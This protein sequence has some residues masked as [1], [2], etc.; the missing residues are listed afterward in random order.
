[1]AEQGDDSQDC[2][3]TDPCGTLRGAISRARG[4]VVILVH[5]GL[6]TG[7][8]QSIPL[9]TQTNIS[10]QCVPTGQND[11]CIFD[12]KGKSRFLTRNASSEDN[13]FIEL[14]GLV[15]KNGFVS[16]GNGGLIMTRNVRCLN[17]ENC[18]FISDAHTLQCDVGKALAVYNT[19]VNLKNTVFDFVSDTD[20]SIVYVEGLYPEN[21]PNIA[22]TIYNVTFLEK[23]SEVK[24]SMVCYTS[25]VSRKSC[26]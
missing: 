1:M 9:T 14:I 26:L 8:E 25:L 13:I 22:V 5:P 24:N 3:S 11:S 17:I 6:Y 23:R 2:S 4:G 20:S 18:S 12:L 21:D 19:K 7:V 15:V 16:G 10:I